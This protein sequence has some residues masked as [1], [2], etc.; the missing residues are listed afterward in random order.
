[1]SAAGIV[2]LVGAG[3]WDPGLLTL[4]GKEVLGRVDLVVYDYLVNPEHLQHAPQA[5]HLPVGKGAERLSQ[6]QINTLLVEAGLVGR[7]VARLKGGDPFVFGRGGEEAAVLHAADVYFEMVPGV[8]AAIASAAYAGIPVTH[9]GVGATL[10]F[11][12]GHRRA[13]VP[14]AEVDW[15][16]L[17]KVD[18]VV[19]YMGRRNL[20]SIAQRLIAEGRSA[21]TP[22][23]MVQWGTRPTQRTRIATLKSAAE[24]ADA[25][26]MAP[27]MTLIV[28]EVVSL[29]EQIGWFELKPLHGKTVVVTRSKGQ[30]GTLAG[31]LRDLGAEVILMPTVAF[32][33]GDERVVQTAVAR[34]AGYDW[35]IFT[36][37]NAVD[38]FLDAIDRAGRDA[39]AFGAAKI[40]C[41]GTQSARRLAERGLKTDVVPKARFVAE[42]LLDALDGAQLDGARVLMPRAAVARELIPEALRAAGAQVDVVAVYHTRRPAP[43]A[44]VVAQV[45]AQA[46]ILLFTSSSTAQHFA[47]AFT[48]DQLGALQQ[49]AKVASIGPVTSQTA[50]DL[51]FEIRWQAAPYTV[52]GLVQALVFTA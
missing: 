50:A 12:T 22:V 39:R 38:Y 52:S 26:G 3:P 19:F 48:A 1:M 47:A 2:Y 6:A 51:G 25:H 31:Q 5:E 8:T 44:A 42:G 30:Q 28:G 32:E 24:V 18:T 20:P 16:A 43:N 29:R 15:A 45:V 49:R 41:V 27:P 21:Q 14:T 7:L 10:A 9:R 33:P 34:L 37:A 13:D 35:V 36:S 4:R 23:A 40:A 11:C 17:A 46:D